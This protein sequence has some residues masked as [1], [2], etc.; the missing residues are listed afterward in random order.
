MSPLYGGG[1]SE[2]GTTVLSFLSGMVVLEVSEGGTVRIYADDGDGY[3]PE[4]TAA[5]CAQIGAALTALG[6]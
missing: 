6:A 5:D 4:L 2:N 3:A 1:L